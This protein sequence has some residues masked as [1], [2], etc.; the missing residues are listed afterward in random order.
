MKIK[1]PTIRRDEEAVIG[2]GVQC[3]ATEV[4]WDINPIK[5]WLYR[6]GINRLNK[7]LFKHFREIEL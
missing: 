4:F 5:S 3:S 1:G 7:F 6:H 2:I